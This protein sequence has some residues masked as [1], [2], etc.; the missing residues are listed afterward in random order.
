M[1]GRTPRWSPVCAP[2]R[3]MH[4]GRTSVRGSDQSATRAG[5][6]P[7]AKAGAEPGPSQPETPDD[8][9][10]PTHWCVLLLDR[11]TERVEVPDHA[12]TIDPY[13]TAEARAYSSERRR[14]TGQTAHLGDGAGSGDRRMAGSSQRRNT[15]G[16]PRSVAKRRGCHGGRSSGEARPARRRWPTAGRALMR[17]SR[18]PTAQRL[19]TPLANRSALPRRRIGRHSEQPDGTTPES[20]PLRRP[21][22]GDDGASRLL[23]PGAGP[24]QRCS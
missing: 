5:G 19:R 3:R 9:E 23:I 18:G 10:A 16:D 7:F 1:R 17:G 2:V 8:C 22:T 14:V 12:R 15:D 13:L 6:P 24:D 11:P 20:A 4:R 21:R